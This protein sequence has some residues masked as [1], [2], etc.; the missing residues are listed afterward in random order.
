LC[1]QWTKVC[2]CDEAEC[3]LNFFFFFF[4]FDNVSLQIS[5]EESHNLDTPIGN[6]AQCGVFKLYIKEI[7]GP[8]VINDI[9]LAKNVPD[10]LVVRNADYELL[11]PNFLNYI[12]AQNWSTKVLI[13]LLS[14]IVRLLASALTALFRI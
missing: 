3:L 7:L 11:A 12:V 6:L 14:F 8:K 13:V 4:F 9:L 5:M 10:G 1:D 2:G